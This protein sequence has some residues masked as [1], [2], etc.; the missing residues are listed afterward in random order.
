MTSSRTRQHPASLP[1][2]FDACYRAI[3]GRDTRWDG[4]VYLGVSST[5]IYCRPSCPARKPIPANCRFFASAAACVAAG[6]RACKRCRPDAAPGTRD[7]DTR[8]DLAARAVRRIRDGAVDTSGVSGLARELAVSERHLYRVLVEEVGA[9]PLQ[10]ARTRRAHAARLLIEQ[11]DLPLSD[12]AFAA[13]FGSLRQ[14]GDTMREEF[15]VAPSLLSRKQGDEDRGLASV[16]AGGSGSPSSDER[17]SLGLQLRTRLPYDAAGMRAFLGA[18]AI[19]GRD[20]VEPT[21]AEHATG[22]TTSHAIDVPGGTAVVR[23]SWQAVHEHGGY[24]SLPVQLSL[25]GIADTMPAIAS[26][27]RLLDLDADPA[28]I[29]ETLGRDPRLASLVELRPGL[30]LPGARNPQEFALGTVLG[31]QVSLAAART[32]QGRLAAAFAFP[33]DS[34][35][36]STSGFHAAP[37]VARI[38]GTRTMELRELIGLPAA[39]AETLRSL[40]RAL[41]DGLD[42][43]A[44]A[45]REGARRTLA[46]LRGIGPWSVELIAMRAL[47]D[48]DAYPAGDLI[49]RRVLGT[50]T[51]RETRELAEGWRP[52]RGYATQHLWAGFLAEQ[53]ARLSRPTSRRQEAP[54]CTR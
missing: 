34:R 43:S 52:Y 38:A 16:Q 6:F 32:L 48:P 33:I 41:A 36:R 13:G 51:D 39:R 14:F 10:L 19:P 35:S 25:P 5:G 4:R 23:I 11:T 45:D 26:I 53:A 9:S 30:R 37:D 7:W 42:L 2:D 22:A 31:Q 47:G 12:I 8:G 27:R 29:A 15:G 54:A 40:A 3:S 50:R 28:Q 17:P 44:G 24:T 20:A 18:H 21:S 46:A 1:L 49:L